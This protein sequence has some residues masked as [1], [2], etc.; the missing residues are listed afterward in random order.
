MTKRKPGAF[1]ELADWHYDR[2]RL[3][4]EPPR[5][6]QHQHPN[7]SPACPD[8]AAFDVA[9]E[10]YW[11]LVLA[12]QI[13]WP[14]PAPL[15]RLIGKSS[16]T[17]ISIDQG[18]YLLRREP[19]TSIL[20][21]A[22]H[23]ARITFLA[24]D[25]ALSILQRA[26][27]EQKPLESI[28]QF[29]AWPIADDKVTDEY[30]RKAKAFYAAPAA[31]PGARRE[32]RAL[33]LALI[34]AQTGW[35]MPGLV[36]RTFP[37]GWTTRTLDAPTVG[38]LLRDARG[39]DIG[40]AIFAGAH[41]S[42]LPLSVLEAA[43]KRQFGW[44]GSQA[45]SIRDA[46]PVNH[47]VSFYN[48]VD[49]EVVDLA[50]FATLAQR[51]RQILQSGDTQWRQRLTFQMFFALEG[52]HGS[53]E[54]VSP[55]L[56]ED[57]ASEL[58]SAAANAPNEQREID[59]REGPVAEAPEGLTEPTMTKRDEAA[60][61]GSSPDGTAG[62][63]SLQDEP[64]SELTE[65]SSGTDPASQQKGSSDDIIRPDPG[66][67]QASHVT[68]AG[69]AQR[70][71]SSEG[72]QQE[73]TP[74]EPASRMNDSN[75]IASE[76]SAVNGLAGTSTATPQSSSE[77]SDNHEGKNIDTT[78][79]RDR[80]ILLACVYNKISRHLN[81]ITI[82]KLP[83][84]YQTLNLTE[85]RI[86]ELLPYPRQIELDLALECFGYKIPNA[87]KDLDKS[88]LHALRQ[89]GD[90]LRHQ[91]IQQ[92][93]AED[94]PSHKA[95]FELPKEW[96]KSYSFFVSGLKLASPHEW[97]T[98]VVTPWDYIYS[99]GKSTYDINVYRQLRAIKFISVFK[100]KYG[101]S[102]PALTRS[103][104]IDNRKNFTKENLDNNY[105]IEHIDYAL[106]FSESDNFIDQMID[107]LIYEITENRP[108]RFKIT[109]SDNNGQFA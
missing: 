61:S 64:A 103:K 93:S 91:L 10:A 42:G 66:T 40:Q 35:P 20:H 43:A 83:L 3:E 7:A 51:M 21:L 36:T 33:W 105:V 12:G 48:P 49:F 44:E 52:D 102:A 80:A 31:P 79:E 67:M 19:A 81:P 56:P 63:K 70:S 101:R 74:R 100:E 47:L 98:K 41:V 13:G 58:A 72:A 34:L 16:V 65:L 39:F 92:A 57:T 55:S 86:I 45:H 88:A 23:G 11:L 15:R 109:L 76:L 62:S 90:T 77:S 89:S 106:T 14:L 27:V 30:D 85:T 82:K 4:R 73:S 46:D 9:Q 107:N 1:E 2:Y 94:T 8:P 22:S 99:Y 25:K 38:R 50:L 17:S 29:R 54:F 87:P 78:K 69:R 28:R 60:S 37:P 104:L 53:S 95:G 97:R 59:V 68:R 6:V 18:R 96:Q 32:D 108:E 71:P 5:Q 24:P 26:E 84:D 75:E